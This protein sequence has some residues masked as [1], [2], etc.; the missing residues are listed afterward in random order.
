MSW[1]LGHLL[2]LTMDLS[3]G[4]IGMGGSILTLAAIVYVLE[5]K[6]KRTISINRLI[7]CIPLLCLLLVGCRQTTPSSV[8]T[9]EAKAVDLTISA[10]T[11][12][13]DVMGD[14]KQLYLQKKPNVTI[15]YNFGASG[16]LQQQIEQ[17]APVDVFISAASKQMDA[18]QL[19]GLLIADTRK[20]LLKNKVVLIVPKSATAIS[21]FK[22]L[23]G[24]GVKKV[25]LGEPASVPVGQYGQEV[26][27]SVGIFDQVKPKFV[28]AKDVRQVLTYVETGNVDAGILYQTDAKQSNKVK[29]VA[30]ASENSHSPIIYPVAAIKNSKNTTVAKEFVQF[31]FSAPAGDV[32]EKYGF[33]KATGETPSQ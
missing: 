11:S 24:A 3:L 1:L 15:T 22:D 5:S 29:V 25:A 23:T 7:V 6:P 18:L 17:G 21:D 28:F 16:S 4:P 30:M 8:S 32:F 19:K 31:L 26:L 20:N 33:I 10:A 2:A 9:T 12:L 13:K 27:T 14:I